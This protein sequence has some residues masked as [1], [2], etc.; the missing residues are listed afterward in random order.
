MAQSGTILLLR[1]GDEADFTA[2]LPALTLLRKSFPTARIELVTHKEHAQV[3]LEAQL[4]DEVYLLTHHEIAP[5]F[6]SK[7]SLPPLWVERFQ[8]ASIVISWLFDPLELFS[9]HMQALGVTG[10]LQGEANILAKERPSSAQI[11]QV[12]EQLALFFEDEESV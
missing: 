7:L 9:K 6:S 1:G 2:T 12:L 5:F 11:A 8:Q 3:A 4:V 10:F